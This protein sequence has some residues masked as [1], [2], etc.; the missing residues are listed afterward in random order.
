MQR[1]KIFTLVIS[2]IT[3]L[4]LFSGFKLKNLLKSVTD[5]KKEQYEVKDATKSTGVRGLD[6]ESKGAETDS[7]L[8]GLANI[9]KKK[10]DTSN[11]YEVKDATKATGVRGLDEVGNIRLKRKSN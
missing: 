3:C 7:G 1:R 10:K 6:E 5:E 8:G 9:F 4:L 2:L 11:S